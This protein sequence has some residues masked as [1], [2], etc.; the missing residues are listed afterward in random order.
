MLSL[1][2]FAVSSSSRQE[3]RGHKLT[4]CLSSPPDAG[5]RDRSSDGTTLWRGG[6]SVRL[7]AKVLPLLPLLVLVW[8]DPKSKCFTAGIT[9]LSTLFSPFFSLKPL[10]SLCVFSEGLR[11]P[12]SQPGNSPYPLPR[13]RTLRQGLKTDPWLPYHNTFGLCASEFGMSG[14]FLP[15]VSFTLNYNCML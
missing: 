14:F 1:T 11:R 9:A 12:R 4:S 8:G 10:I 2:V 13:E 6:A 3:N 5:Q 15:L 7:L